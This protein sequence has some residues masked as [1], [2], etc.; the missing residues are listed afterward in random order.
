MTRRGALFLL[1][2]NGKDNTTWRGVH[3]PVIS[4]WQQHDE[5]GHTLLVVSRWDDGG[6]TALA[7][8]KWQ[9]R[10]GGGMPLLIAC[11]NGKYDEEGVCPSSSHVVVL[12]VSGVVVST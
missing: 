6:H 10:R 1:Y 9:I 2:R 12:L 3:L 7:V 4:R 11:R 5:E 8:S